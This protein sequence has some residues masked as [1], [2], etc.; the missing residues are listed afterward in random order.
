M[1]LIVDAEGQRRGSGGAVGYFTAH[2]D[3]D[4]CIVTRSALVEKRYRHRMRG[5]AE[6]AGSCSGSLKPMKPVI[7]RRIACYRHRARAQETF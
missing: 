6:R 4:T 2:G 7:K 5:G 1:Q 3:L